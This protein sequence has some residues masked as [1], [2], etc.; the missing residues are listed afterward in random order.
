MTK[1]T[2]INKLKPTQRAIA[3][4][5]IREAMLAIV[6]AQGKPVTIPIADLNQ[7]AAT[8]R[9]VIEVDHIAGAVT[10]T[11]QKAPEQIQDPKPKLLLM[12][13]SQG[14]TEIRGSMIQDPDSFEP[15]KPN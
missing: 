9:L 7:I 15:R 11:A 3:D 5:S 4:Q 13:S 1:P 6:A 12:G 10:L 8:H 14:K 2:H